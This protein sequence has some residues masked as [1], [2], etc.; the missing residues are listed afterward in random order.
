MFE[1]I[2]QWIKGALAKMFGQS[3]L[4]SKLNVDV[5]ISSEMISAL[6]LWSWMYKNKA[7]WLKKDEIFSMGLPAAISSEVA[8]SVTIEMEVKIGDGPRANYLQEQVDRALPLL[9]QMVEFGCAK[10]GLMLKPYVSGSQVNVDFVQADQFYPTEFDANGN[11]TGCVF[12]DQKVIGSSYFTKLEYHHFGSMQ[13]GD[14]TINGYVIQNMAFKSSTTSELGIPVDLAAV[15]EWATIQP[16][17]TIT[18]DQPLFAYFRF[19]IANN[20][21]SGSPLGM[22]CYS[23]AVELIKQADEQWSRLLWEF[24][25]G[26][27]ALF[28]DVVAFDRKKDGTPILPM[29]R[30]YRALN[31]TGNIDD[32]PEGLFKDWSPTFREES[33]LNGLDAIL[34]KIEFT[35]GLAYGTL[36]DPNV[37]E[38]TATEIKISKQRTYATISDT[39]K[40]LKSA[41]EH[42]LWAMDVWATLYNLAPAGT[43]QTVYDFDDSIVTDSATQYTMDTQ[44]VGLGAM[45]LVEFRMRNYGED[46]ATAKKM[47]QMA[48]AEK[49]STDFFNPPVQ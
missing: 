22:S 25:S 13:S 49:G 2:L 21:D 17:A 8:R 46:E 10:G 23:R 34:K 36:S 27:R 41:L 4:K 43:Y 45:G 38:K 15:P 16:I 12:A 20:I 29:K 48:Q 6:Q 32:N 14:Q 11:I 47:V 33:I 42:L 44:A 18:V 30:L 24:E 26:E 28:A 5:A 35:C 37:E 40:A 3:D 31:S 9:R 7:P 19:P 1:K 39:Q